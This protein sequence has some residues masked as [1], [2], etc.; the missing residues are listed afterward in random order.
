LLGKISSK[1]QSA[2]LLL[3]R[4]RDRITQ[5]LLGHPGGPYWSGKDLGAWSI[6][7][8]LI[9]PDEEPIAAARREFAEETGHHPV[10]E[11]IPLGE[12]RQPGGKLIHVWAVHGDWN[13][14]DLQSN[15]FEMEWPPRSGR[16][17]SFPEIDRAAW[18]G[19]SDAQLKILKGQAV[20]ID[21]LFEAL[22]EAGGS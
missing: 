7:K 13:P 9:A 12:A 11:L 16:P 17:Q 18:F 8:G 4:K 1:P 5:L 19:V 10:G 15:T 14:A 3:F 2:G 6:P 21:R 22:G 20:F